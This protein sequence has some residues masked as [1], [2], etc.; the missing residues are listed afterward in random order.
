MTIWTDLQGVDFCLSTIDAGGIPTRALVAGVGPDVVFLHGTSGHLEAFSRNIGPHVRAGLRCHAIDMLGHGYTAKPDYTYEIPR[1]VEHLVGYLDAQGIESAHFVG[2]SLGGW[3][4][5]WLASEQPAR[6]RSLQLVAA[7][8]TVANPAIMERIKSSTTKAVVE[9]DIDF[10]RARLHLLMHDK[11]NVS[12]ELVEIRHAIYHSPAFQRNLAH[13][14]CLQEME[15][16]ERNLLRPDRLA[17][18]AVVPTLIV[19]GHENPF[20]DVPE[21]KAMHDNIDGSRLVLLEKCG[22]W[23]QHEQHDQF[24]ELSIEFITTAELARS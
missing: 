2:E 24:N 6:V 5:G 15:V 22:H 11:K 3:V 21:A 4:A 17:R 9:D 7:G 8:G 16:R 13:L 19:W 18:L 10:T 1:Y 14:L 12:D 23:P 20:G